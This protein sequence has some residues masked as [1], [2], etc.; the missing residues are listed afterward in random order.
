MSEHTIK[1][2]CRLEPQ[3]ILQ[4]SGLMFW[5]EDGNGRLIS[6]RRANA[7]SAW[8]SA[9]QFLTDGGAKPHDT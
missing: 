4:T 8:S 7:G 1:S 5:V 2:V 3:A 9:Y 6:R